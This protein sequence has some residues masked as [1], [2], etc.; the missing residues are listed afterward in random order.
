MSSS[1]PVLSI[2]ETVSVTA[3]YAC[4]QLGLNV[5]AGYA[6][7]AFC[8]ENLAPTMGGDASFADLAV[9]I[10][11]EVSLLALLFAAD[12]Q[13]FMRMGIPDPASCLMS[14]VGILV[15]A[16]T[17]LAVGS[18]ALIVNS[19]ES[20][21]AGWFGIDF[22]WFGPQTSSYSL[23]HNASA[24][25]GFKKEA[26]GQVFNTPRAAYQATPHNSGVSR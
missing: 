23:F 15:S 11:T 25:D 2:V 5:V 1:N 10:G 9:Y 26:T 24:P 3:I 16:N 18:S 13:I 8:Y 4:L 19:A 17:L 7:D 12:I 22:S 21:V 6:I 14:I 20:K